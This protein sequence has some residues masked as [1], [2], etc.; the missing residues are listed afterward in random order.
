MFSAE[1]FLLKYKKIFQVWNVVGKKF[2]SW[3]IF[4]VLVES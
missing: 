4:V 2:D 3:V 1:A